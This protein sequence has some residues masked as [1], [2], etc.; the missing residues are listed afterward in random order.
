MLYLNRR[1]CPVEPLNS[2]VYKLGTAVDILLER[3]A[4]S[5][6]RMIALSGS[7]AGFKRLFSF[8]AKI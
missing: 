2:T 1:F 4:L 8:L 6:L 7:F 3:L 5:K